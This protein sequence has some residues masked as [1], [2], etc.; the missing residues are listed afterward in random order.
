MLLWELSHLC[1]PFA[2]FPGRR[3]SPDFLPQYHLPSCLR[4]LESTHIV[5]ILRE[6][7]PSGV[8]VAQIADRCG[9]E[10]GRVCQLA[11]IFRSS[12][13]TAVLMKF[14]TAHILRLLATHHIL[15]EVS[16]DV[17]ANN[18]VSAH[19]DTGKDSKQLKQADKAGKC[20]TPF[21]CFLSTHPGCWLGESIIQTLIRVRRGSP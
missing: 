6:A 12:A 7:G 4:F 18:R 13:S 16:P 1:S 5:E 21:I 19:M 2:I 10:R 20:A 11:E 8:H 15:R 3:K 17:F 14:N 9:C